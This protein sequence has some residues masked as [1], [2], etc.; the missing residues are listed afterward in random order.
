MDMPGIVNLYFEA[1]RRNDADALLEAFAVEAVVK[2]EGARHKGIAAIR[3]WW[4]AAKGTAQ[5]V[6]EPM[7]TTVEDGRTLVRAR[8]SGQFPGSP[9]T[10]AYAFTIK[11]DRIVDLE[12]R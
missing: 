5:Y 6:A 1:D 12:I 4:M 9:V 7:E 11:D 3:D 8:V 2:D 10:L